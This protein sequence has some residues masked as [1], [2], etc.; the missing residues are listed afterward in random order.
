MTARPHD[1]GPAISPLCRSSSDNVAL[2][3]GNS[4]ATYDNKNV[5]DNKT[6]TLSGLTLGG[7]DAGNY[8]LASASISGKVGKITP[9]AL[10]I[11]ASANSKVLR[12]HHQRGGHADDQRPN[13]RGQCQRPGAGLCRQE[14]RQRQDPELLTA[15]SSTMATAAATT[16]SPCRTTP[17][18]SSPRP[19]WIYTAATVSREQDKDTPLLSGSI[20]GIASGDSLAAVT[21]GSLTWLTTA[22]NSSP[23]GHCHHR[24]RPERHRRQLPGR[25]PPGSRQRHGADR[26]GAAGGRWLPGSPAMDCSGQPCQRQPAA[27]RHRRHCRQRCLG[28]SRPVRGAMQQ[29]RRRAGTLMAVR[30]LVCRCAS[31]AAG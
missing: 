15:I 7:T 18:A 27:R 11:T 21:S 5:G 29:A 12:R 23:A 26:A 3:F 19:N 1:S 17:A 25:H 24:Q 31:S 4:S 30:S 22:T 2:T 14:R 9:A 10:T 6:V 20:G 16:P 28:P 8:Q 13:G